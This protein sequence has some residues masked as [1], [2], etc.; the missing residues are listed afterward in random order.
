MRAFRSILQPYAAKSGDWVGRKNGLFPQLIGQETLNWVIN[1]SLPHVCCW[2]SRPLD[3]GNQFYQYV[4]TLE[5]GI[6]QRRR[7]AIIRIGWEICF[8]QF[9]RL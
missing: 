1:A 9:Y 8:E 6:F 3:L 5:L 7:L 4:E 2:I